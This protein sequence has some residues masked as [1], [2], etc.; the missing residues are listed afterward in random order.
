MFIGNF[1]G[2]GGGSSGGGGG[3]YSDFGSYNNQQSNY[4]P[5]K[6]NFGGG[7]SSGGG[8]NSGPYGGELFIMALYTCPFRFKS[9]YI[10]NLNPKLHNVCSRW[11]W[12]WIQWWIWWWLWWKTVLSSERLVSNSVV[13]L[14]DF[15]IT[16]FTG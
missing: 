13:Y 15:Q 4:G 6:G 11:L 5:M 1:G 12:R 14:K 3:N 2:G 9:P 7:G 8:R 16:L 10:N